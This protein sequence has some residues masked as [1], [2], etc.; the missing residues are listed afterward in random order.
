ME[1]IFIKIIFGTWLICLISVAPS[2]ATTYTVSNFNDMDGTTTTLRYYVEHSSNG[3]VINFNTG[4][5]INL[6][7]ILVI[8]T[9]ITI[10]GTTVSGYS[11]PTNVFVPDPSLGSLTVPFALQTPLVT[12]NGS[13]YWD[14]NYAGGD[15]VALQIKSDGVT[16]RGLKITNAWQAIDDENFSTISYSSAV[17]S[18]IEECVLSAC[19]TGIEV[20][21]PKV[22][23]QRNYIGNN[24]ADSKY[25][26]GMARGILVGLEDYTFLGSNYENGDVIGEDNMTVSGL[27]DGNMI[28][29]CCFAGVEIYSG[30]SNKVSKNIIFHDANWGGLTSPPMGI[31]L[32]QPPAQAVVQA[33][34]EGKKMPVLTAIHN[35][36]YTYGGVF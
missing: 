20:D 22:Y 15:F 34:N 5:T 10:D 24:L 21:M 1:K 8:T 36:S 27:T 33:G 32:I 4:G 7:T 3:D 31:R 25:P 2:N 18:H 23:I 16:I 13:S 19:W 6:K 30:Y 28:Q 9:R 35:S 29:N 17:A 12:I 26:K 14:F 11:A